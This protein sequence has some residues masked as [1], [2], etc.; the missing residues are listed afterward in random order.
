MSPQPFNVQPG[1]GTNAGTTV[2]TIDSAGNETVAGSLTVD[3]IVMPKLAAAP[4]GIPLSLILYTDDGVTLKFVGAG[5]VAG[6]VGGVVN[7]TN[8]GTL[9]G[10]FNAGGAIFTGAPDFRASAAG[11]T[12]LST[13]VTGDSVV[14]LAI[15]GDG[16]LKW[17]PGNGAA[18]CVLDRYAVG[19]LELNCALRFTNGQLLFG[20]AGDVDLFWGGTGL[21]KTDNNFTAGGTTGVTISTVGGGLLVKEGTNATMGRAVLSAGAAT[22]STTKVT[23][24]SEIFLTNQ[25]NGGTAG[26]L[27]VSAR[28]AGVSFAITS[29]NGADTS[30]IAWMIVEPA[31]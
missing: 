14:R 28:T 21:L 15:T 2:A 25:V 27:R 13:D 10:T 26:F 8:G 20:P 22:V 6:G 31:P 3:P 11:N 9:S 19:G 4:A 17:G 16:S 1:S 18:D 12:A 24:N 7:L 30:T 29:S 5:G 23:A